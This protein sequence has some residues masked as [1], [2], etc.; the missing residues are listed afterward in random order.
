MKGGELV[1]R[2]EARDKAAHHLAEAEE[3][4]D[5][6]NIEKFSKRYNDIF[7]IQVGYNSNKHP[8]RRNGCTC[9]SYV[10]IWSKF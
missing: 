9:N 4:G 6:E 3:K 8:S 10:Q 1:K 7:Y 2:A 5:Q